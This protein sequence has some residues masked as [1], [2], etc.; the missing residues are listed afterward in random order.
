MLFS[1]ATG[2]LSQ[3]DPFQAAS[4][5]VASQGIIKVMDQ[6]TLGVEPFGL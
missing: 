6:G 4:L 2:K 5:E 1:F 3:R